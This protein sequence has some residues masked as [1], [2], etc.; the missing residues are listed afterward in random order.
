MQSSDL[1]SQPF[2]KQRNTVVSL[3]SSSPHEVKD[4]NVFLRQLY[5]MVKYL[6]S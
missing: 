2:S 6:V 4:R 5:V 3:H 1:H